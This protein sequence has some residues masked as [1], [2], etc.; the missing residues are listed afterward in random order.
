MIRMRA[1][2]VAILP[3]ATLGCAVSQPGAL[4]EYREGVT[5]N[6]RYAPARSNLGF[7]FF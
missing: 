7:T 1:R 4:V 5:L 2:S 6:F 3:T